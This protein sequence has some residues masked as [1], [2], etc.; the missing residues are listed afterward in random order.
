MTFKKLEIKDKDFLK[1]HL[2]NNTEELCVYSPLTILVWRAKY[3]YPVYKIYNNILYIGAYL[4]GDNEKNH[5]ILPVPESGKYPDPKHLY[6]FINSEDF[7]YY[8]Y[9]PE[10]Y[11]EKFGKD[12]IEKY[13]SIEYV[14]GDSDYIYLREN[15]AALK[16]RKYSKKRNLINQFLKDYDKRYEFT[17]ITNKNRPEVLDFIEEWCIV[18]DCES[19]PESDIYCEK[20]AVENA[21]NNADFL[22]YKTLVLKIDEEIKACALS[23]DITQ[24]VG[25]LHF[26]KASFEIKGLYQFFDKHC[27]QK[28]FDNHIKYINKESDMDDEGLRQAKKSYYPVKTISSYNLTPLKT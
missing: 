10:T 18:R 17:E 15:L 7:S 22:G 19:D 4:T 12:E 9:I 28:L 27:A 3:Y 2:K 16:G 1:N 21:V 20:K 11:I 5:L 24:N 14:S 6:E 23:S 13:F 8:K 25:G 26:Q